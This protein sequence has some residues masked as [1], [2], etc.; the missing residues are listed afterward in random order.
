MSAMK[1]RIPVLALIVAFPLGLFAKTPNPN[2]SPTPKPTTILKKWLRSLG[3][4]TDHTG[5]T[6]TG[7]KGLD[8]G[9]VVDPPKV[10]LP[11]TKQIK[12]TIKLVNRGKKLVQL[13]FPSSQRIEVLVKNKEGKQIEQWSE[14]QAFTDEPSM[15]TVNPDERVEYPVTV[16]TRDMVVGETYTVEAFFPNFEQLRKTLTV[17]AV[18]PAPKSPKPSPGASPGAAPSPEPILNSRHKKGQ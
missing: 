15:V 14:D 9:L 1:F 8:I 11:E 5:T 6:A 18:T 3:L 12:V 7:F 17:D 10:T 13:N 2:A 4:Q 16:S